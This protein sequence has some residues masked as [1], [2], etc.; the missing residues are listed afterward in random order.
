M[1]LVTTMTVPAVDDLIK[2]SFLKSAFK[3]G[4]NVRALFQKETSDWST[5]NKR[6][7]EIDRER[8]GERKAQGQGSAQRGISQGYFK[9][10]TRYTVSVT[11]KVSGEAFKAL[12]DYKLAEM[13][14]GTGDDIVDKI[15]LDMR[16]F[17]GFGTVS[18]YTDNGGYTIDTTGGD[19]V[20]NFNTT[21]PL[22]NVATT[23]SNILSGT[24][25]LSESAL[26][27][28]VDYFNYNVMD[29]NGQ[30]IEMKPNTLITSNKSAMVNRATRILNSISPEKIEGTANANEGVVNT[31]RN[32]YKH[33]VVEFDVTA[34]NISDSTKSFYWYVASLGGNPESSLQWYYVKWLSPEVAPVEINQ[35]KWYMSWTAR[36]CLGLG[37]VSS[38]GICVSQATA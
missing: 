31:N 17:L 22:K 24:P 14:M 4:G 35:D 7:F 5:A 36:A 2:K 33:M 30:R 9:D 12:T 25:A 8:F 3:D 38:K 27:L 1:S 21:H 26:D 6:I 10:I 37:A 23:Y 29:N 15:E 13:A 19:G 32:K 34:F 20:S 16:N 28:A 18:S 11:R